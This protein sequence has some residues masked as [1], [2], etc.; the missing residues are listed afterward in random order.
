[1]TTLRVLVWISNNFVL[2]LVYM[3]NFVNTA[4]RPMFK[5][6]AWQ[7]LKMAFFPWIT[8]MLL[9]LLWKYRTLWFY[10]VNNWLQ[11]FDSSEIAFVPMV[12]ELAE[13]LYLHP[14]G[15]FLQSVLWH[16]ASEVNLMGKQMSDTD[17]HKHTHTN[18][19]QGFATLNAP[20]WQQ[21]PWI[22]HWTF[23]RCF[24]PISPHNS[25]ILMFYFVVSWCLL[26]RLYQLKV[27]IWG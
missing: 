18:K 6:I 5:M 22:G 4:E 3:C 27:L 19:H 15:I 1:M 13:N 26:H 10:M 24:P 21:Q 9:L 7:S 12:F 25:L 8:Q 23:N 17:T 14:F 2:M 20:F 16:T 11:K